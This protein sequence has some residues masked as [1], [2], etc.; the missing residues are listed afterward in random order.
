VLPD[1]A[2]PFEIPFR[3]KGF[4]RVCSLSSIGLLFVHYTSTICPLS[5]H[6]HSSLRIQ[7]F[8][9]LRHC[10]WA[11][12]VRS[13][14]NDLACPLV[15]RFGGWNLENCKFGFR[16]RLIFA[17][18]LRSTACPRA[19]ARGHAVDHTVQCA[20]RCFARCIVTCTVQCTKECT[21]ECNVQ[22]TIKCSVQ[23]NIQNLKT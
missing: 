14:L 15:I 17:P 18:Y 5:V 2:L 20:N 6:Y 23:R 16:D 21:I 13:S 11:Q 9:K 10:V 22:C 1:C 4:V 12:M 19:I 8:V 7:C 3:F